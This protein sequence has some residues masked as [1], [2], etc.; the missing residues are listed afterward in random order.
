MAWGDLMRLRHVDAIANDLP[1]DRHVTIATAK[2]ALGCDAST[3]RKMLKNGDLEGI[4]VR[5]NRNTRG[6]PRISVASIRLYLARMAIKPK[7]GAATSH[8]MTSPLNTSSGHK[9]AIAFLAA[10]GIIRR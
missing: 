8:N 4:R 9:A 5:A 1:L 3:I 10:R 7:I 6:A 2:T